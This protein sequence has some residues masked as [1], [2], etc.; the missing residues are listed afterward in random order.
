MLAGRDGSGRE[1]ILVV[2]GRRRYGVVV[3]VGLDDWFRLLIESKLSCFL[4]QPLIEL[5]DQVTLIYLLQINLHFLVCC[6]GQGV[7]GS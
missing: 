7:I 1:G 6:T 3:M 5:N 2:E 4:F